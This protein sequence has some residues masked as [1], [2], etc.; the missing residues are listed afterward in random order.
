MFI[1]QGFQVSSV[2]EK[3]ELQVVRK[4][5]VKDFD[6]ELKCYTLT[7]KRIFGIKPMLPQRGVY[8]LCVFFKKRD[9]FQSPVVYCDSRASVNVGETDP[10]LVARKLGHCALLKAVGTLIDGT[11]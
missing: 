3:G 2:L 5:N 9:C 8:F 7:R 11:S 10:R 6:K 4:K 1:K